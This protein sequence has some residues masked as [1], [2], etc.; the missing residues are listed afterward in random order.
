MQK[1]MAEKQYQEAGCTSE[2]CAIRIGRLL[3]ADYVII[4]RLDMV[5]GVYTLTAGL[6][7]VEVE[8]RRASFQGSSQP[9]SVPGFSLIWKSVG[10][11]DSN[12]MNTAV[13][14]IEGYMRER[15]P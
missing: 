6:S 10:F 9:V 11:R 15:M 4:G 5:D 8:K 14:D 1:I 13:A 12:S 3:K 2:D 7:E